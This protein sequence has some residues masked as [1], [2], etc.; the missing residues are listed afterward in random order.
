LSTLAAIVGG[1]IRYA[2]PAQPL[3]ERFFMN[4]ILRLLATAVC[5]TA[6]TAA[7]ASGS[8]I[9][10]AYMPLVGSQWQLSLTV[11]NGGSPAQIPGF[12]VYFDHT[13]FTN[14]AA[15]AAPAGWDPLLFQP[16][17]S[18]S[19]DGVFDA[20]VLG[21]ADALLPGQSIGGFSL[22]FDYLGAGAPG[23]LPF[24][25]YELDANGGFVPLGSGSVAVQVVPELGTFWLA[26][27]GLSALT[28]LR[29][30]R[31][32]AEAEVA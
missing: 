21:P 23:T 12:S 22:Q 4:L 16:L 8:N 27:F 31:V 26:T 17:P 19:S 1:A 6:S 5:V 24:E 30:G 28:L 18:I 3:L 32:A 9:L 29:R 13:L 14:L 2:Q 10:G 25:F 7:S 15:P 11:A 20:Y